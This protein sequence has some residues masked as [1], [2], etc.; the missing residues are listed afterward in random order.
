[1]KKYEREHLKTLYCD[2]GLTSREVARIFGVSHRSVLNWLKKEGIPR[3]PKARLK[4]PPPI[5]EEELFRL[6]VAERKSTTEIGRKMGCSPS[7]V[8]RYLKI[9]GINPRR[10]GWSAPWRILNID[11]NPTE[12]LGYF[13]G[14][15]I[16]DGWIY[17]KKNAGYIIGFACSKSDKELLDI[18]L[19]T[20][21]KINPHLKPYVLLKR[22]RSGFK[23]LK[24]ESYLW[25]VRFHSKILYNA[26][27]PYKMEDYRWTVPRFLKTKASLRGF[28]QGLS[29]AEGSVLQVGRQK[30]VKITSKHKEGLKEVKKILKEV[31]GIDSSI[32]SDRNGRFYNLVI[33][34]NE[35]IKRFAERINFKL[36]RKRRKLRTVLIGIE[37]RQKHF[38]SEQEISI[39]L[40]NYGK[41]T[42]KEIG[43]KIGKSA[44]SIREMVYRLRKKNKFTQ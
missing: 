43:R 33:S 19:E 42:S 1:V 35:S 8:S 5:S 39:L 38:W 6:Y 30:S 10:R 31:F 13:C 17:K 34:K 28:L 15:I 3:R 29:D 22:N 44:E 27:K 37:N 24:K 11:L 21:R 36:S 7:T 23:H 32:W 41:M 12:E 2:K 20:I 4:K 14:L 18:Y 9:Y 40:E 16:G 26:L 25:F